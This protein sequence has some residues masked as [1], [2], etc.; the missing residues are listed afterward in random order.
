MLF[1][2]ILCKANSNLII[3]YKNITKKLRSKKPD[4]LYAG[5]SFAKAFHGGN[6]GGGTYKFAKARSDFYRENTKNLRSSQKKL[7]WSA[8]TKNDL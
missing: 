1:L 2:T 3:F 4:G 7:H 8:I 5:E 6:E